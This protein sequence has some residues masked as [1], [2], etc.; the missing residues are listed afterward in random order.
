V[1][2]SYR[3][4]Q[5]I[6]KRGDDGALRKALNERLDPNL[7]NPNGWSLLMLAAVEGNVVLGRT[8]LE[9]G[10]SSTTANSKGETAQSIAASR[11]HQ[12]FVDLLNEQEA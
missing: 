11:G 6:I 7:T 4:S 12:P 3:A 5:N 10:A 9:K 1:P 2:I 8:L